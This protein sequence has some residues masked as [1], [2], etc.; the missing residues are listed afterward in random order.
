MRRTISCLKWY[1]Q[2]HLNINK[3]GGHQTQYGK[4]REMAAPGKGTGMAVCIFVFLKEKKKKKTRE[5]V[6]ELGRCLLSACPQRATLFINTKINKQNRE[7]FDVV[8]TSTYQKSV[9][10]HRTHNR[11]SV[12][13]VC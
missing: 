13:E 2:R 7:Y 3:E 5:S 9:A 6:C 12:L 4:I 11:E 8:P 10:R 1:D